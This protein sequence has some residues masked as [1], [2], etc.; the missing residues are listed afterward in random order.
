MKHLNNLVL[1]SALSLGACGGVQ[2]PVEQP[3]TVAQPAVQT[4]PSRTAEQAR[5]D[6][7]IAKTTETATG[8]PKNTK[9]F[10]RVLSTCLETQKYVIDTVDI[11]RSK[12]QEY[13]CEKIQNAVR[14]YQQIVEA[15]QS[16]VYPERTTELFYYPPE[17]VEHYHQETAAQQKNAQVARN[18][19]AEITQ[20]RAGQCF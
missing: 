15:C 5:Q 12:I 14:G 9:E 10:E 6:E 4:T 7:L 17:V 20:A 2:R 19:I 18:L 13:P 11:Y 1:A 16:V 3:P 8:L